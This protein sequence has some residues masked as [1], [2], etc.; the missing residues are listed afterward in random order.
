MKPPA[1]SKEHKSSTIK[2]G[3]VLGIVGGV[4]GIAG[5]LGLL[6]FVIIRRS[7]TAAA[8]DHVYSIFDGSVTSKRSVASKKS[9]RRAVDSSKSA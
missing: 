8:D 1:K 7:K 6:I 5:V 9:V 2:L 3:I 4:L